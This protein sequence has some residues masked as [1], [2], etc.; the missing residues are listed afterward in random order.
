VKTRKINRFWYE[1]QFPKSR[2]ENRK[3]NGFLETKQ[4]FG[5]WIGFSAF[6]SAFASK[7]RKNKKGKNEAMIF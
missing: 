2:K 3:S 1:I 4:F 6:Q 7:P 5:L